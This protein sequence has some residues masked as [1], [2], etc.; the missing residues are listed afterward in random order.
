MAG[1]FLAL[2]GYIFYNTVVLNKNRSEKEVNE[3]L[4]RYERQYAPLRTEPQ[5]STYRIEGNMQ[6]MP[7]ERSLQADFKLVLVNKTN[8]P[9]SNIYLNQPGHL[10]IEGLRSD[11]IWT[12][13]VSDPDNDFYGYHFASPVQPGD[14]VQ[15]RY[16]FSGNP[17]G[18]TDNGLNT[19]VNVNGTFLNNRSFIPVIGYDHRKRTDKAT[20]CAGNT[21]CR[22]GP[23]P[24]C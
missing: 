1:L 6:I 7:S 20:S 15:L 17:E 21:D 19:L 14:S 18:F 23:M 24:R 13:S 4:A 2:G 12:S 10:L 5:L 3:L 11:R 16:H 9:V 8:H 22:P